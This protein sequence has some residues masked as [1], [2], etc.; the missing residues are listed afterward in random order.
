MLS[1]W[2]QNSLSHTIQN[3]AR[4][5]KI[6]QHL[7]NVRQPSIFPCHQVQYFVDEFMSINK[8]EGWQ[9]SSTQGS[10]HREIEKPEDNIIKAND[11]R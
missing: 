7:I 8:H 9:Q 4:S 6:W 2:R 5:Y 11:R 10:K 3:M 1:L